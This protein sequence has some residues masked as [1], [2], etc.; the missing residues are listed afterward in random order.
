MM[1]TSIL[2]TV[3]QDVICNSTQKCL[4][5]EANAGAAKTTTAAMKIASLISHG[6]DPRKIVALAFSAPGV[7]AFRTA[8]KK[9]GV[10]SKTA[11]LIQPATFDDYCATRLRMLENIDVRR[12]HSP[13]DFDS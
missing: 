12:L 5:V 11:N 4:I 9:I 7:T 6:M 3:E 8:F 10:D 13:P 1:R 2:K